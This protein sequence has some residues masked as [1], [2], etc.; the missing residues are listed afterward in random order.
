M[1]CW[2]FECSLPQTYATRF[3]LRIFYEA[4]QHDGTQQIDK[5]NPNVGQFSQKSHLLVKIGNSGFLK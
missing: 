3:A 1:A 4:L 5:S 2:K